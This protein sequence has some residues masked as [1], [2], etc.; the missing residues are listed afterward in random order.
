MRAGLG[1]DTFC[2]DRSGSFLNLAVKH[3]GAVPRQSGGPAV[4]SWF[5]KSAFDF[6][7]EKMEPVN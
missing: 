1:C 7:Y 4:V 2:F 6:E 3:A 5:T